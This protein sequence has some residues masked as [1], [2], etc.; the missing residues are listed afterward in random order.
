M[1]AIKPIFKDLANSDL[2][3]KCLDGY[4]QNANKSV[5]NLIWKYCPKTTFHGLTVV[6]TAVAIAV[7]VYNDGASNIKRILEHMSISAGVFTQTFIESKDTYRVICAQRQAKMS[8]KEY[9]R[10]QR[11]RR[12]GIEEELAEIEG[13]PYVAGGY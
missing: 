13:F 8:S 4:T 2:L 6:Q 11:L 1:D 3:R 7:C 12:L 5:N 10:A 9:R